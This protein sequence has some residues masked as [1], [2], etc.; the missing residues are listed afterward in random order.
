[1]TPRG[2]IFKTKKEFNVPIIL[3]CQLDKPDKRKKVGR[4]NKWDLRGT[5]AIGQ[6]AETIMF[7]HRPEI[8]ETNMEKK[9]L[10]SGA[11]EIIIDKSRNGPTGIVE[12]E[13]EKAITHFKSMEPRF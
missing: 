7:V 6:D 11:A 5:G 2:I 10:L 13:F 1:M 3:L 4:P 9:A 12:V 8:H